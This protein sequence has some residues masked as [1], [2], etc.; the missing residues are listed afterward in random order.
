MQELRVREEAAGSRLDRFL[1]ALDDVGSRAAAERLIDSGE[2]TVDGAAARSSL[3]LSEGQTVMYPKREPAT[4]AL[5]A[6]DLDIPVLYRDEH[7]LVV[8]KPAGLLVHP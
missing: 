6:V 7:L 3:R 1:A 2:V 4:S 5:E 8:D